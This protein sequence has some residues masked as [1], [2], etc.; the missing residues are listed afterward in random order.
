MRITLYRT[1]CMQTAAAFS[2]QITLKRINSYMMHVSN[3]SAMV[4]SNLKPIVV[5]YSWLMAKEK[6]FTR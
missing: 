2:R 6:H 5:I 3:G 4:D 1:M